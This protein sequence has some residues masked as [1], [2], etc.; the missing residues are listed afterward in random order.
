MGLIRHT[1]EVAESPDLSFLSADL[2]R[3][4]RLTD[5]GTE[6]MWPR[7]RVEEVINALADHGIVVLGLDLRSDGGDGVTPPGL[8]TE[9][10]WIAY[11]PKASGRSGQIEA[12]RTQ[13]LDALSR[14]ELADFADYPWAL[15]SW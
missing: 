12:A 7:E 4:A 3:A 6:I 2:R 8:A 15:V 14:T 13:A 9:V 1:Q 11:E 5:N 10:P